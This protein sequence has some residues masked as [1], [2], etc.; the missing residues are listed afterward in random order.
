[1]SRWELNEDAA[2]R[3][4]GFPF[5]LVDLLRTTAASERLRGL[6]ELDRLADGCRDD[7]LGRVFPAAVGRARTPDQRRW[8]SRARRE[9]GRGR[10]PGDCPEPADAELTE[11][12]ARWSTAAAAVAGAEAAVR[13][14]WVTDASAVSAALRAACGD[15]RLIDA[16]QR[17]SGSV[18]AQLDRYQREPAGKSARA[19]ERRLALYLQRLATKNETNSFF[20]PVGR[21]RLGRAEGERLRLRGEVGAGDPVVFATV[22]LAQGLGDVV[23]RHDVGRLHTPVRPHPMAVVGDLADPDERRVFA[24]ADGHR[25]VA[26]IATATGLDDGTALAA[27]DRLAAGGRA[28]LGLVVGPAGEDPLSE[29]ERDLRRL[30]PGDAVRSWCEGEIAGLRTVLGRPDLDWPDRLAAVERRWSGATGLAPQQAAGRM[31]A[32]RTLLFE[33]RP[34]SL[35]LELGPTLRDE[36]AAALSPVLDLWAVVAEERRDRARAAL[37]SLFERNWPD[38]DCVPLRT[39]LAAAARLARSG[40]PGDDRPD[41]PGRALRVMAEEIRRQ[42]EAGADVVRLSAGRLRQLVGEPGERAFSSVDVLIGAPDVD[43]VNAGRYRLVLGECHAPELLSVF[44]TDYFQRARARATVTARTAWWRDAIAL[45]GERLA[46]IVNA[47]QT[48]IFGYPAAAV[49]IELRP[50]RSQA[51]AVAA[52]DVRV[53]RC[54]GSF[55]LHDQDGP[56]TLLPAL[57]TA[58]GFDP[59]LPFSLPPVESVALGEGDRVPRIEID[60]ICVQ[61]A[62]AVVTVPPE[63]E[64]ATGADRALLAWRWGARLGLGERVFVRS[65]AER[66]PVYIDFASPP[67]VDILVRMGSGGG[68]LQLSELLPGTDELWLAGADGRHSAE[69]RMLAARRPGTGG[70]PGATGAIGAPA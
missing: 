44:P 40:G 53:R 66:K 41:P 52:R 11:C 1:M 67:L 42:R 47:R 8:L 17:M 10:A 54:G 59:L 26:E 58:P 29:V 31:Y 36:I 22:R 20:G 45:P 16:L 12:L 15:P 38:R 27:A 49:P 62:K 30:P 23:T 57:H 61:R 7:L 33:E 51:G 2:F 6:S 35:L 63:I 50:T 34:S 64:R 3:V 4:T 43:A 70:S 39:Y 68:A 48:K 18:A 19:T 9:V 65:A 56:L 13:A 32:D 14:A 28:L 37:A 21:A 46:Y 5:E 55:A 25:S 60:R 24:A 69:L